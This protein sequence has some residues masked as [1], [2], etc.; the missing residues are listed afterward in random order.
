MP[1][2]VPF[3]VIDTGVGIP[4][5]KLEE[6]FKPFVQADSATARRFGGTGL[7][8][9]ISRQLV[10]LMGGKLTVSSMVG[11]GSTFSFIIPLDI[12]KMKIRPLPGRNR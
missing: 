9:A 11:V 3:S 10:E 2:L 4:S 5:T 8:L 12:Q 1:T 7:G 6:I